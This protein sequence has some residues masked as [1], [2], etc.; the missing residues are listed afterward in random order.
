MEGDVLDTTSQ[1]GQRGFSELVSSE[2]TFTRLWP[3]AVAPDGLHRL[4]ICIFIL[5]VRMCVCVVYVCVS[6]YL[7]IGVICNFFDMAER[8]FGMSM[9]LL[10]HDHECRRLC[11]Y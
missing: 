10:S 4:Y 1:F 8:F 3:K 7:C 6:I 11:Q 2:Q 9:A 5:Y